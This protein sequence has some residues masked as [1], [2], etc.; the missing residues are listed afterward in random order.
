MNTV[1]ENV[2]ARSRR[3]DLAHL[4][5]AGA[6]P[7]PDAA[8]VELARHHRAQADR[9]RSGRRACHFDELTGLPN[10]SPDPASTSRTLHRAQW[11]RTSAFALAFI[12]LDNFKH[13]NDYY[14]HAVGDALLVKI[15]QRIAQPPA[16]QR[17]ARAH[18]RRRVPAAA[19]SD[20]E[21][22][23]DSAHDRR[24]LCEDL[25][26]PFHIEAF[27]MFTLGLDRRQPLS[28]ARPQ[29]RGAA[30]Q[31]RQRHVPGQERRQGRRHHL[32]PQHGPGGH[33]AHGARAAA[34]ARDPRPTVL[35]RVPA[36]GRHPHPAG[37]RLRDAGPLARRRRRDPAAERS[38]SGLR[39][40]SA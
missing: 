5:Q 40:S 1:E 14:S 32:R 28:G 39:S 31:R 36:Q 12:D 9:E 6:H 29:L 8:A 17:H 13:I 11:R 34:A 30:T 22:G 4:A 27:E 2:A 35:L 7:R 16:R 10:R 24:H 3:T 18:Q 25:K 20:R 33:R 15:A 37:G 21:R 38:S 23:A 19:R 26:Q